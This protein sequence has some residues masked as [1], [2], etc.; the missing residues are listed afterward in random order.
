MKKTGMAGG[1]KSSLQYRKK[2]QMIMIGHLLIT[3]SNFILKCFCRDW[4]EPQY[5][6]LRHTFRINKWKNSDQLTV[7]KINKKWHVKCIGIFFPKLI[8]LKITI[9]GKV[10]VKA[11]GV[12]RLTSIWK[13]H[14]VYYF[15]LNGI[16]G[17]QG[18]SL[19][20]NCLI[21]SVFHPLLHLGQFSEW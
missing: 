7:T 15:I 1:Y 14:R 10:V 19:F 5:E 8:L 2:W 20:L 11:N 3:L 4:F 17:L 13:V 12:L 21:Y 6:L 18:S 9:P 16:G